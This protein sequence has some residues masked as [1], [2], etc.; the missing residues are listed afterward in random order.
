MNKH[1]YIYIFEN[2]MHHHQQQVV[3]LVDGGLNDQHA[4]CVFFQRLYYCKQRKINR[5]TLKMYHSDNKSFVILD[6]VIAHFL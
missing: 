1:I 2:V 3:I 6:M 4:H 5:N